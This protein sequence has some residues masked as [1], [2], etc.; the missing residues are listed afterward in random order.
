MAEALKDGYT[1][2]LKKHYEEVVRP[3]LIEEFGYTNPMQVPTIEKIVVN[4]GVGESTQDSKKA[5][6]AAEDL[7][8]IVGQKPVIT[9]ARKA[10]ATFKVR[11]NMPIGCKVTLRKQR[12]YEFM[13]RLIT[14]ALPRVRDFRGLNPKSFDGRGN[15][16]L[17]IKEHLVFPEI[18]YD[19]AQNTWGMDIVVA[20]TAKTDAE[21]RALLKHFNFPFRQ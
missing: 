8:L 18:N 11:E 20:T 21:A 1:P 14:I 10:I 4:M 7:G 3:K 5:S 17:G 15:Y 2:R 9:R 12:M 19:K 6:V 16:A 13:D